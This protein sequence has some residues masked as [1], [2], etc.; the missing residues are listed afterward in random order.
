MGRR[1]IIEFIVHGNSVTYDSG[2]TRS[3]FNLR[4]RVVPH[5]ST[6]I[7]VEAYYEACYEITVPVGDYP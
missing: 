7:T 5:A 2:W 6:T 3:N 1:K 4:A